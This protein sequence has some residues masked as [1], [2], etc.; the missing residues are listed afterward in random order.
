MVNSGESGQLG[1]AMVHSARPAG[2]LN[3]RFALQGLDEYV[4]LLRRCWAQRPLD[5]PSFDR[6]AAEL[7]RARLGF[8]L[9]MQRHLL[10]STGA[11]ACMQ[12]AP[13]PLPTL[14]HVCEFLINF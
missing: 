10:H 5:R 14:F 6:I 11:C 9:P 12:L 2:L 8:L 1:Q 7:R 3:T 13:L 4:S